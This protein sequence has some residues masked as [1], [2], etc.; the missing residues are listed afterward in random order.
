MEFASEL[1][2]LGLGGKS[3]SI[4]QVSVRAI[5]IFF[6]CIVLVRVGDKRFLSRKSAL[7]AVVGFI[8]ASV[9]SRA[10][11]GSAAL[12]PT[13]AGGFVIVFLHRGLAW[14][15]MRSH[16]LGNIVKG[17]QEMVIDRG[18]VDNDAMRRNH[19]TEHDLL[20]DLRINGSVNSPEEVRVAHI[21][22]NGEIS[23]IRKTS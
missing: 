4:L 23:V 15:C 14:V 9:M 2:G 17:E 11:N 7:D 10:I 12:L 6:V 16:T 18:R 20:E 19:I 8:L 22:R 5:V 21:E 13:I 3:L 1:L